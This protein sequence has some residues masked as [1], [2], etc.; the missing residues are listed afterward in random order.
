MSPSPAL[1][2]AFVTTLTL[3]GPH[4]REEARPEAIRSTYEREEARP[5]AIRSTCEREEARPEAIR[6]T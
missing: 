6:S 1:R 2:S 5:E 3:E 4:E